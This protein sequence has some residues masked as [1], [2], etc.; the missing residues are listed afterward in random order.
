MRSA[1]NIGKIH[2]MTPYL[3]ET[4]SDLLNRSMDVMEKSA[5][6]AGKLHPVTLQGLIDFLRI[7]NTYYS[8]LI[9]DH[10]THPIDIERAMAQQYDRDPLKRDLQIEARVHVELEREI[11]CQIVS[12]SVQPTSPEFICSIHKRFY[13]QL[14]ERFRKA[15]ADNETAHISVM[16]GKYRDHYV[17][18]GN[19]VPASPEVVGL[20]MTELDRHYDLNRFARIDKLPAIAA[21]HHRLMWIHPFLDGNGRVARLFTYACMRAAGVVGYGLWSVNRGFAHFK[22]DYL[23]ALADAD[24]VRQGDLDGRG[25]LTQKG[26][27]RF[28]HFF[29]ETC[30]DQ[31]AFME[32]LL[33]LDG[34]LTRI[35]QYIQLRFRH[36]IPEVAPLRPEALHLIREAFVFGEFARGQAARLTGLKERTARSLIAEL[37]ADGLL[38]SDTPKGLLRLHFSARLLPIWFPGL[39]PAG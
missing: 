17:K 13:E 11:D 38:V 10:H 39:G 30:L 6:L 4:G 14:P 20:F 3:P 24:A 18:V 31:I 25:H 27:N 26:L 33:N 12:N 16:P 34:L 5:A 9:E 21:A 1:M 32:K 22:S 23:S 35:E 37:I 8:N 7:T 29:I 2:H 19:L 15:P 28:C 36:L